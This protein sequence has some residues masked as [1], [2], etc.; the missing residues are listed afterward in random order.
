MHAS[1][2]GGN[3]ADANSVAGSPSFRPRRFQWH[4]DLPVLEA[5]L[6]RLRASGVAVSMMVIDPIDGF[7]DAPRRRS[8][9]AADVEK[10]DRAAKWLYDRLC[11]RKVLAFEVQA[12]AAENEIGDA[13]LRRAFRSLGGKTDKEKEPGGGKARWYW[14]LPGECFFSRLA[15]LRF[16]PPPIPDVGD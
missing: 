8:L 10:N 7:V 15:G 14:R 5:E 13:L 1:G 6:A 11:R 9:L 4:R 2:S 12:E 3:A 16:I